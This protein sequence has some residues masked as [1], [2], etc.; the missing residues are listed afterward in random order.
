MNQ[1]A[2]IDIIEE[3]KTKKLKL[4]VVDDS[5]DNRTLIL[6]YLNKF[7]FD[8]SIAENGEE[9]TELVKKTTFDIIFMDS[10]MPI[11][12]GI[13]AT[14][15]IRSWEKLEQVSPSIIVALSAYTLQEEIDNSLKAG[16]N[17]YLTKPIKKSI[18]LETI[19]K[20][21]FTQS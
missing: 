21:M 8:I 11:M 20:L 5:P 12:D 10:D 14:L 3:L 17:L 7:P 1:Q 19:Y 4:L 15:A 9:A 6:A 13:A 18:L 2:T 16:T